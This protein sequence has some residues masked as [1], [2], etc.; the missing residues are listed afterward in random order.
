[1]AETAFFSTEGHASLLASGLQLLRQSIDLCDVVVVVD[2][3]RFHAHR[4]VL[5][6]ISGYFQTMFLGE[7]AERRQTEI[8]LHDVDAASVMT[9]I[10]YAYTGKAQCAVDNIERLYAS[11]HLL[12]FN[13]VVT[14]CSKV[15]RMQADLSNC[16]HLGIFADRYSDSLLMSVSDRMA[17]VN[18]VE[19]ADTEEF[20]ALSA[21]HL[22]RIVALDELGV[23]DE[24]E[25]LR[26][27]SKWIKHDYESRGKHAKD[28]LNLVRLPLLDLAK[29][30]TLLKLRELQV[31]ER[32][33]ERVTE[34][35]KKEGEGAALPR[36]GCQDVLL[37]V[38]GETSEYDDEIH[39]N[40]YCVSNESRYYDPSRD[41]WDSFPSLVEPRFRPGLV[42]VGDVLYAVGGKM[43]DPNIIYNKYD[44]L[45]D[46]AYFLNTVERYDS[47]HNRWVADVAPMSY[48]RPG[49]EVTSC[50]GRIF[51]I[52]PNRE[53]QNNWLVEAYDS[54]ENRWLPFSSPPKYCLKDATIAAL[55]DHIYM[56]FPAS[57]S[58]GYRDRFGY[59]RYNPIEDRWQSYSVAPFSFR[60]TNGAAPR[61]TVANN[62]RIN[63]YWNDLFCASFA[64]NSEQWSKFLPQSNLRYSWDVCSGGA[65]DRDN[66]YILSDS[67][68]EVIDVDSPSKMAERKPGKKYIPKGLRQCGAK[69]VSRKFALNLM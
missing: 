57:T 21:E 56:F 7:F 8:T 25:V 50:L 49:N 27:I 58:G 59:V 41:V 33:T 12:Q 17:A 20:L 68:V 39:R 51:G 16:L 55:S 10:D 6:S 67:L 24:V 26:V 11:A 5:A 23:R 35:A 46:H 22:C 63:F 1:M 2:G 62:D 45:A 47:K 34:D 40:Y 19:V 44:S 42:T 36:T 65:G 29:C 30:E 15:L 52:S 60:L 32:V 38:G 43:I 61:F 37:V 28:L 48:P 3:H 9:L 53:K 18:I 31:G 13:D 66:F 14:K 54:E 4:N 69:F 64:S